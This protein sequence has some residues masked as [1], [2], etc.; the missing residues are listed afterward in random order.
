M[1]VVVAV[2]IKVVII[3]MG[4]R[5]VGAGLRRFRRRVGRMITRRIWWVGEEGWG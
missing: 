1:G 2:V 5:V 4:S 3:C